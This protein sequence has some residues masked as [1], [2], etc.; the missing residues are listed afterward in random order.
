M[1]NEIE[2][3]KHGDKVSLI[4]GGIAYDGHIENRMV[5]QWPCDKYET[6]VIVDNTATPHFP[7]E[8]ECFKNN[9][10]NIYHKN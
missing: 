1:I 10:G 6:F 8:I 2:K 5:G 7:I 4:I 3:F 9:Y